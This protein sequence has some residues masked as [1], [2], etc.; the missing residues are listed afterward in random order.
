MPHSITPPESEN[1]LLQIEATQ[2]IRTREK[3]FA[4]VESAPIAIITVD[5]EGLVDTWNVEAERI[6]DKLEDQ[7]I[8]KTLGSLAG[9][10]HAT[11]SAIEERVKKGERIKNWPFSIRRSE[12][13]ILDLEISASPLHSQEGGIT[14]TVAIVSDVT[15]RNRAERMLQ[16]LNSELERRVSERTAELL[17]SK[18]ELEAFC[19]SVSHDLRAPL[20]AIDGF[21]RAILQESDDL[22]PASSKNHLVRVRNA[23][24]TP[25]GINRLPSEPHPPHAG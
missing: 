13:Q 3:L 22:L 15:Q 21:S 18:E 19:F 7:A 9:R 24:P 5:A 4:I 20:R 2:D 6:F 23:S 1:Q 25:F 10:Q 17:A 8:G 14:G 12:E 16:E 11:L